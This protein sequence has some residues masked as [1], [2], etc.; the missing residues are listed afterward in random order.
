MATYSWNIATCEH[1]VATGG[2][3]AA[4][5]ECIATDASYT[6]RVYGA[7]GLN[8][9]PSSPDFIAYANVTEAEVLNWVW[10]QLN[11]ADTEANLASAIEA[12]K[13]PTTASGTPW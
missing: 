3:T 12:Q 6:A 5:W 1:D 11:K 13:N 9:D 8:P 2:I 4:H 10:G 7:E